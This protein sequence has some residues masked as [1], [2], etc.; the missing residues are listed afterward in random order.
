MIDTMLAPTTDFPFRK[1]GLSIDRFSPGANA[2]MIAV[3]DNTLSSETV[4]TRPW[5]A[6]ACW[7][8][9]N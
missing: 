4:M 7:S 2:V 9:A 3:I 1:G 6:S 5:T 8:L